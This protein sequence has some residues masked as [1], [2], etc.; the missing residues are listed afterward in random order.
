[1]EIV[2]LVIFVIFLAEVESAN[3][4][5]ILS[6]PFYSHQ[7]F[8]H[9]VLEILAEEGHNL[10]IFT[11]HPHDYGEN[12]NVTQ[13]LFAET[14]KIHRQY[15]D[16]LLYKKTKMNYVKLSLFHELWAHF[17]GI[18]KELEHPE[19]QNLIKNSSNY[20]FDLIILECFICPYVLFSEIYDCPFSILSATEISSSGHSLAG[21]DVNPMKYPE[22]LI[23]PYQFGKL[24]ILEK[25]DAIIF[26]AYQE[27]I[28]NFIY[29]FLC[30]TI[31][32]NHFLHLGL[33]AFQ[34]P[35]D[36][37]SLLML[38]T[39][40]AVGYVRPMMPHSI[41]I[42]FTHVEKPKAI[43]DL[44]LKEFLDRSTNG[45]I[46]KVLGS[47]LNGKE[48]G[49][50]IVNKF[51]NAF[52][53]T[54]MSVLWKL[55]E[56]ESELE[57]P[58]NVKIVSWLPLADVLAHP[59]VK[60]LI[61]HGGIFT[62]YEAIDRGVPMIAFPI[63]FDQPLNARILVDKGIGMEMDLNN[64]DEFELSAAIQEMTKPKYAANLSKLK[65]LAY[66]QPINNRDLIVW[67]VNNAIKNRIAYAKDFGNMNYFGTPLNQI[68]I[69]L[70][71]FIVL[72]F[73]LLRKKNLK[74]KK[75]ID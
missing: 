8:Q 59:N 65:A 28:F 4:L 75:K 27:L 49:P 70:I 53:M 55:D 45:V 7:H 73:Y 63:A 34:P 54:N 74:A 29:T 10:T 50:E 13:H 19:M 58:N 31:N 6:Y 48:L 56:F 47:R 5:A 22:S 9:K 38:N 66:D 14:N 68:L 1:M 18:N 64:F 23:L 46:V 3:I 69:Y 21:N 20:H 12:P 37:F 15:S 33:K 25:I 43:K 32:F 2:K 52:N 24:T 16:M 62:L 40:H 44:E 41:Q 11:S 30:A 42:G 57:M 71:V 72:M 17:Y 60:L 36:R 61:F 26:K 39:N 35:S 51:A 67:H